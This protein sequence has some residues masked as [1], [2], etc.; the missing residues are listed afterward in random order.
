MLRARTYVS[1]SCSISLTR[2]LSRT[3]SHGLVRN[4]SSSCVP[5]PS[6]SSPRC[7]ALYRPMAA[8]RTTTAYRSAW[9]TAA[10]KGNF[11]KLYPSAHVNGHI[12]RIQRDLAL[13]AHC[14]AR[15]LD[16]Q[17]KLAAD[18]LR[19]HGRDARM[20]RYLKNGLLSFFGH[21][22]GTIP[23][24]V[25]RRAA[26]VL[27]ARSEHCIIGIE[28]FDAGAATSCDEQAPSAIDGACLSPRGPNCASLGGGISTGHGNY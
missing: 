3:S 11:G 4:A 27:D 8:S 23:I 12:G 25:E 16:S 7:R 14:R 5:K 18:T 2:T 28:G 10:A 26:Q 15:D 1:S 17:P 6:L 21:R 22:L 20:D 9:A 19:R 24:K 13:S